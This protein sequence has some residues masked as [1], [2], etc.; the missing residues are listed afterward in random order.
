MGGLREQQ[1]AQ[2]LQQR[3]QQQ[4]Q[5]QPQRQQQQMCGAHA[6]GVSASTA[7]F[8]RV[9]NQHPGGGS[10]A[11][12][13]MQDAD[14]TMYSDP[15]CTKKMSITAEELANEDVQPTLKE[16]EVLSDGRYFPLL[17]ETGESTGLDGEVFWCLHY[18]AQNN[19]GVL[20]ELSCPGNEVKFSNAEVYYSLCA[21]VTKKGYDPQY[22]MATEM[23]TGG[24]AGPWKTS[25]AGKVAYELALDGELTIFPHDEGDRDPLELIVHVLDSEGF[26]IKGERTRRPAMTEEEKQTRRQRRLVMHVVHPAE[27][28]NLRAEVQNSRMDSF[29]RTMITHFRKQGVDDVGF[30]QSRDNMGNSLCKTI[31]FA[32][33]PANFN[34]TVKEFALATV[35]GTKYVDMQC[36]VPAKLQLGGSKDIGLRTCCF[37]EKCTPGMGPRGPVSCD[38]GNYYMDSNGV[39][40]PSGNWAQQQGRVA[41]RG[42]DETKKQAGVLA[43]AGVQGGFDLNNTIQTC[44]AFVRGRCIKYHGPELAIGHPRRCMEPHDRDKKTIDCCS[45]LEPGHEYYSRHFTKCRYKKIGEPCQYNCKNEANE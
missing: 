45:I 34:G 1:D 26:Q 6:L 20:L 18:W 21:L 30:C 32:N 4:Q 36:R 14:Q 41:K 28:M 24:H 16:G 43:A 38:A 25:L 31:I 3:Q 9:L 44:R 5:R 23:P 35:Q 15:V 27:M 37:K 13:P 10:L 2:R 12:D 22:V 29:Q 39:T 8:S 7:D 40:Q 42:V 17:T 33:Y 11:I 19:Q